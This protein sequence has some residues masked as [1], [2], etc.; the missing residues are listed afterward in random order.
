MKKLFLFVAVVAL[1]GCSIFGTKSMNTPAKSTTGYED[2][3]R[4][5]GK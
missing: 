1:A 2:L 5:G 4:G 3:Y